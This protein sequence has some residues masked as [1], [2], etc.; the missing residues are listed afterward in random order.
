MIHK[1]NE[2]SYNYFREF[3]LQFAENK[4]DWTKG[5]IMEI[6]NPGSVV[7]G[8][9]CRVFF[10]KDINVFDYE[11]YNSDIVEALSMINKMYP[12]SKASK[13][14][15]YQMSMCIM[16]KTFGPSI[17]PVVTNVM[18]IPIDEQL[19]VLWSTSFG[20]TEKNNKITKKFITVPLILWYSKEKSGTRM[21]DTRKDS[22]KYYKPDERFIR[23]RTL[24]T[25][26]WK[27]FINNELSGKDVSYFTKD[28]LHKNDFSVAYNT[29]DLE[30][31]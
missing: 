31:N 5:K 13:N 24:D 4:E 27:E 25:S 11:Q 29:S 8:T 9:R 21:L 18:D 15:S 14:S 10:G 22:G 19:N 26:D 6:Q 28:D 30:L 23:F 16:D 12:K 7:T 2:L 20:E 3:F 17:T 1:W